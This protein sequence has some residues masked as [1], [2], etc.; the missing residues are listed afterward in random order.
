MLSKSRS[1]N[2]WTNGS[3]GKSWRQVA[4]DA[5]K[6]RVTG[7]FVVEDCDGGWTAGQVRAQAYLE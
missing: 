4:L 1:I 3:C 7:V 6:V 2:I 5:V